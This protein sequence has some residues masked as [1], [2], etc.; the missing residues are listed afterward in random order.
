MEKQSERDALDEKMDRRYEFPVDD[1]LFLRSV[2][3][4]IE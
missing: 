3:S 4:N 2:G 1:V